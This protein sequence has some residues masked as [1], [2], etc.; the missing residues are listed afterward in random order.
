MMLVMFRL[1]MPN[2]NS[3]SGKW[4]GEN[5]FYAIVK[6]LSKAT[7]NRIMGTGYYRYSF[8]DGWTAGILVSEISPQNARKVRRKSR[9]FCGYDWMVQSIIE[10][11]KI[12]SRTDNPPIS[13]TDLILS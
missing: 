13:K 4:T 6:N 3:W 2:N 11:N 9:G 12:I 1:S 5:N 7:I 8:G 10:H